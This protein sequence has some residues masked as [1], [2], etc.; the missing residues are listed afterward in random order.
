MSFSN[1]SERALLNHLFSHGN[2]L[3]TFDPPDIYVGLWVGNP[4]EDGASGA[5]VSGD[6]YVRVAE[7]SWSI[8]TGTPTIVYNAAETTFPVATGHWG[9]VTHFV[10]FDAITGGNML[11]Y[12]PLTDAPLEIIPGSVPRFDIGSLI[13]RLD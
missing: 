7:T 10:L 13:V 2:A 12:G 11:L 1:Y 6:G 3:L 9:E 4:G 5:E 8:A